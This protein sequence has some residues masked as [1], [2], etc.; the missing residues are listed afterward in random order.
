MCLCPLLVDVPSVV[1]AITGIVVYIISTAHPQGR[2]MQ[3]WV[4]QPQLIQL[5]KANCRFSEAS[6]RRA[7]TEGC[8]TAQYRQATPQEQAWLKEQGAVSANTTRVQLITLSRAK[9]AAR[10]LGMSSAFAAQFD[11]LPL[12]QAMPLSVATAVGVEPQLCA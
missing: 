5:F 12:A 2:G 9:Q 11:S 7:I 10:D 8:P 4:A 3:H 1:V 6:I